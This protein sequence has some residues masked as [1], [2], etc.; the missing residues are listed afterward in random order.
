MVEF[1]GTLTPNCALPLTLRS[2][3]QIRSNK[4]GRFLLSAGQEVL[5]PL[6][7]HRPQ[8]ANEWFLVDEHG[9]KH[10][11]SAN[12]TKMILRI[13]GGPSPGNALVFINTDAGWRAMPTV[14]TVPSD[15]TLRTP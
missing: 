2:A 12:P 7:V 14:S 5:I 13:Y 6:A 15:A 9:E 10:F 1:S 11:F 3:N 8:R 4:R